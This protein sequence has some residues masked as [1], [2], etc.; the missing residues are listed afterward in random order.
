M[1]SSTNE[2]FS[3]IEWCRRQ[4]SEARTPHELEVWQAEEEG[5]R[6]AI[7]KT[8]HTDKYRQLQRD[9]FVRYEIGLQDGRM[10]IRSQSVDA[11]FRSDRP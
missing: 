5:L 9:V 2:I 11:Q 4:R 7:L 3:R 10:L 8:D 6:D 1:A